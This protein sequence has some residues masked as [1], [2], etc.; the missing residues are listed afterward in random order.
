MKLNKCALDG[1]KSG[2]RE[3]EQ[4]VVRVRDIANKS[5][6]FLSPLAHNSEGIES[7]KRGFPI[8]SRLIESPASYP[9]ILPPS[10]ARHKHRFRSVVVT[11]GTSDSVTNRKVHLNYSL[12]IGAYPRASCQCGQI[13]LC[14][15]IPLGKRVFVYD[16]R[17]FTCKCNSERMR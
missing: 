17:C 7:H 6:Q 13:R 4:G 5:R 2:A 10:A 1:V 16:S 12:Q 11:G 3:R 14:C 15:S 9:T 8:Q